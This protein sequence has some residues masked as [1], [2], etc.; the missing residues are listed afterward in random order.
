MAPRIFFRTPLACSSCGTLNEARTIDLS[1]PIG[2][3]PEWTYAEPGE[4]ID[5][6]ADEL[7]DAFVMLRRP[8]ATIIA[9]ELWTCRA[10]KLQS[11]ARLEFRVRTPR[12]LE[13]V[14]ATAIP[15]LTK[16]ALDEAHFIT[17][18]IEDWTAQPGEDEARLEELKRQL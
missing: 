4:A 10:C 6:G 2:N 1:S 17:R 3:D 13:F 16:E 14:G 15:A 8:H 5:A 9:I 7:E 12:V 11:P 18:K